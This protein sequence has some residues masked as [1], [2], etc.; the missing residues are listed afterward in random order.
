M[1]PA[2]HLD[3]NYLILVAAGADEGIASQVE[4][5]LAEGTLLEASAMT[6]A[7]FRCGPISQEICDTT[8]EVLACI[9]PVTLEI[10]D[11]AGRLFDATGRRSRT[12]ADCI[13]A[14]TAMGKGV[15]LATCNRADFEP[16]VAHGL[17]LWSAL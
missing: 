3:T 4:A 9:H 2:I 16:F 1:P 6:W 7:E 15:P 11:H 10:A 13:I 17:L 8:L 12:L 14:A 5:W